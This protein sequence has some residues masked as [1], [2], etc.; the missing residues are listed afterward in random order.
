MQAHKYILYSKN[1]EERTERDK[2]ESE[3]IEEKNQR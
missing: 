2:D 3:E 1:A